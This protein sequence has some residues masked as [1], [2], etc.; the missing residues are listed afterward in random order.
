[1]YV[2]TRSVF[3][4]SWTLCLKSI[5]H[6]KPTSTVNNRLLSYIYLLYVL[7][8]SFALFYFIIFHIRLQPLRLQ[9]HP[10]SCGC[11]RGLFVSCHFSLVQTVF[12]QLACGVS[13]AQRLFKALQALGGLQKII[14]HLGLPWTVILCVLFYFW[15]IILICFWAACFFFLLL[16]IIEVWGWNLILF[17]WCWGAE[18]STRCYYTH[19]HLWIQ[20]IFHINFSKSDDLLTV[21]V[22]YRLFHPEL[23]A[24]E[25]LVHMDCLLS[26]SVCAPL[27]SARTFLQNTHTRYMTIN[28][29]FIMY[30][31]H[32][33]YYPALVD[34]IDFG[35]V[36][37]RKL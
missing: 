1:M 22:T 34:W 35:A 21:W 32:N 20:L 31:H 7:C 8:C 16:V 12:P 13:K 5:V 6:L 30:L 29:S 3:L 9:F 2:S 26:G 37:A 14:N 24:V 36:G 10:E 18:C 28:T 4:S 15:T 17:L 25:P 11:T 23:T 33:S 19:S 27:S